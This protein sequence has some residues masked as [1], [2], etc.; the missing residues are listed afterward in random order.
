M[1]TGHAGKRFFIAPDAS[2]ARWMVGFE[3]EAIYPGWLD[4]TDWP[5]DVLESFIMSNNPAP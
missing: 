5:D 2:R 1:H 3:Q 4:A